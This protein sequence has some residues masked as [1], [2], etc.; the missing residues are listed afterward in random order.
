[1]PTTVA[2]RAI[3]S[4]Y[5]TGFRCATSASQPRSSTSG[6]YAVE[7]NTARNT[8]CC[9]SGPACCVRNVTAMKTPHSAAIAQNDAAAK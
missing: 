1:M 7:R 3:S 9:I 6:V 2:W 5:V 4:T 8:P